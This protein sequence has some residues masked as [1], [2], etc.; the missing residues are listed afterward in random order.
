MGLGARTLPA[1]SR[2]TSLRPVCYTLD[3]MNNH[4]AMSPEGMESRVAA[5]SQRPKLISKTTALTS[6]EAWQI[7]QKLNALFPP[8]ESLRWLAEPQAQLGGSPQEL[9]ERGE[10]DR[11]LRLLVRLEQG[12]SL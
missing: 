7:E 4:A 3:T 2:L 8:A 9:I 10:V 5:R 12:I 11:I 6:A 1:A